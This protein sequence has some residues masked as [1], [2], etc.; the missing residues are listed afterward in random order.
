MKYID[1]AP[2]IRPEAQG[3]PD[4]VMERAVRDSATEFCQ[5]TDIYVPEPEFITVIA[6]VNEYAVSLPSGTELKHIIDIFDD[7]TALQPVSYSVLLLKLGDETTR[8]TPRYYAQR[9]NLDFYLAPIPSAVDS[10]RVLYSVK[11]SPASTSIPDTIGKEHR[12]TIARGALF[13]LQMMS[14]QPWQNPN[15]A[16]INKQLFE[17]EVGRTVRQVK[18][19]YSGGSLTAKSRAFI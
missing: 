9:D 12:E 7:K 2:Y 6:G 15:A 8:G 13:R 19:G 4:F 17:S 10:L 3:C 16:S 14:G 11:P 1:F 18:Y 5:R